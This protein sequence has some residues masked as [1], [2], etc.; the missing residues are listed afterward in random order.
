MRGERVR[1]GRGGGTKSVKG[2][3]RGGKGNA[4]SSLKFRV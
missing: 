1:E 3:V 2:Q 4:K